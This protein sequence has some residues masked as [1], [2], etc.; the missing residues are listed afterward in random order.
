M[1]RSHVQLVMPLLVI[2]AL[3]SSI[4]RA[5]PPHAAE[6]STKF[7]LLQLP[8]IAGP[9]S[10][11]HAA[12][13]GIIEG[14]FNGVVDLYDWTDKDPGM[15]ALLGYQ[16][17]QKQAQLIADKLAE[18]AVAEPN[19]KIFILCHSGGAGLAVWA[20]EKLPE[21]VKVDT[22]VMMSPALSPGYDL[23]KAL[24]HVTGRLYVFS[25]LADIIVL[26]TGTKVFGTIDG[27]KTDA[28]GRV[29]FIQPPTADAEQY[30]KLV[31]LPFDPKWI[32]LGN[33]GDHIGGM[34]RTF[35]RG[36]LAPLMLEGRTPPVSMPT[37]AQTPTGLGRDMTK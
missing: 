28:A 9:R 7:F 12:N 32:E 2:H 21:S 29:G 5:E 37:T 14:G 31:A 3:L 27:V 24:K 16:R 4:A 34:T 8:G 23:S 17:N 1:I 36:V 10:I 33:R 25:S 6:P 13:R 30:A 20:L 35:G 11:D 15:N 26:S 18:R 22:V 19:G